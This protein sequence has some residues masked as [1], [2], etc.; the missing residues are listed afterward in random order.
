M[1][2][3]I[4]LEATGV[5]VVVGFADF[6]GLVV[7]IGNYLDILQDTGYIYI[8]TY[9][10]IFYCM[11]DVWILIQAILEPD[12]QSFLVL[13]KTCFSS[14]VE[15]QTHSKNGLL[16]FMIA[17]NQSVSLPGHKLGYV[18]TSYF[19]YPGLSTKYHMPGGF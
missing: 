15:C 6:A 7:K 2:P 11:Y 10:Y 4:P 9:I 12:D 1:W 5:P 16:S 18:L 3:K 17:W 19:R 8:Y 14:P 13:E